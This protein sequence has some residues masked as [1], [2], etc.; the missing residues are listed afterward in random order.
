MQSVIRGQNIDLDVRYEDGSGALTDPANPYADVIDPLGT[1]FLVHVVPVR[2]GLGLYRYVF[3]APL[4]A[5][6]STWTINWYGTFVGPVQVGPVPDYFNVLPI[7][8]IVVVPSGSYT[9]DPSSDNG[10]IRLCIDDRDLSLVDSNLP[11][12]QRSCIF[13]DE[14]IADVLAHSGYDVNY[15]IARLLIVIA[16]NRSLL[17]QSRRVGRTQIDFGN[18]RSDL[19]KQAQAFVELA[20]AGA[21][22]ADGYAEI[23]YDDFSI[24][25]IIVN[26]QL[27]ND[28]TGVPGL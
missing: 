28:R 1:Q 5:M 22:P 10:Y 6:L 9:Y 24:R 17:I 4:N 27:R 18:I 20:A 12:E 25:R 7:G 15:A 19:L 14:E 26:T 11:Y 23:A 8:A 2:M 3:A 21:I 16:N 13:S